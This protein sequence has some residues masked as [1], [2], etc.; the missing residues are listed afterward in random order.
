M[1]LV[2]ICRRLIGADST[3][4]AGTEAIAQELVRVCEELG[5]ETWTQEEFVDGQAQWNVMACPQGGRE[6]I[7]K[8]P[9]MLLANHLDTCEPGPLALWKHNQGDPFSL[10]IESPHLH[11]LGIAENKGDIAAKILALSKINSQ[12]ELKVTPLFV[13]F[14]GHQSGM[15]GAQRW[16]K[17]HPL[18]VKLACIGEP[19]DLKPVTHINGYARVD[20]LIPFNQDELAFR[21]AHQLSD[22]SSSSSRLFK[23]R[24]QSGIDFENSMSLL[25]EVFAYFDQ[26]PDSTALIEL[27]GGTQFNAQ[28][29]QVLTEID[30]APHLETAMIKKVSG[31]YQSFAKLHKELKAFA[32]PTY[33]PANLS[34]NIGILRTVESQLVL[35]GIV[36]IP[37][38]LSQSQME[39]WQ[40]Q[41]AEICANVGA[42]IQISDYKPPYLLSKNSPTQVLLS[43]ALTRSSLS[44]ETRPLYLS[45]E[46]C[47]LGRKE[48]DCIIFGPGAP[49]EN[50][51]T[52]WEKVRID[53]IETASA[54]YTNLI[55]EVSL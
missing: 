3:P 10:N 7:T 24:A 13:G 2:E 38:H 4:T 42:N 31:L 1:T 9:V 5:L 11:G 51:H 53:H 29:S 18:N 16:L 6:Q 23:G 36:R 28:P 22:S 8:Q 37:P 52:P 12:H 47:L 45:N 54:F 19:T 26:L 33:T 50:L 43:K 55:E 27:D 46:A 32:D 25:R 20:I 41:A 35:N 30:L 34:F 44:S 17:R 39:S 49:E 48:I 21:Q 40:K 15:K 14:F